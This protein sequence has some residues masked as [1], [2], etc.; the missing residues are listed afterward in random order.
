MHLNK[1]I[2]MKE[3]SDYIKDFISVCL[4]KQFQYHFFSGCNNLLYINK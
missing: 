4:V 1:Y 3:Y 2:I